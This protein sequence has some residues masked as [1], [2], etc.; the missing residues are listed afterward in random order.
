MKT[1]QLLP[2]LAGLALATGF[3]PLLDA[4]P[5]VNRDNVSVTFQDPDKFTD[6]R[7][8]HSTTTSTYYLDELKACLQETAAPLLGAGQKLAITVTDVDLAGENLFNQ[9]D[10]IRIMKEI[11]APRVNLK[12]QLVGGDGKVLKEGERR[13]TDQLY[14]HQVRMPGDQ[15]PL[16]YDKRMIKQWVQDEFRAKS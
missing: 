11:Y 12:F 6:V 7:E 1:R 8:N 15:D 4:A 10:Q 14:L 3:A 2:L 5:T 16:H 13:L 9:P